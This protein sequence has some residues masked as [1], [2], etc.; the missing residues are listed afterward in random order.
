MN[1]KESS[2]RASADSEGG[3]SVSEITGYKSNLEISW[4]TP[5]VELL[6]EVVGKGV[7]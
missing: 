7:N 1:Q 6:A 4:V 3:A 5:L 2:C